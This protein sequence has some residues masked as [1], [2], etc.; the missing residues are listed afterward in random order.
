VCAGRNPFSILYTYNFQANR[1]GPD[2]W[3]T[4]FPPACSAPEIGPGAGCEVTANLAAAMAADDFGG[5]GGSS[6]VVRTSL[7]TLKFP[8]VEG[9]AAGK[10]QRRF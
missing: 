2:L 4:D 1:L 8:G 7:V 9:W 6:N 3:T 5:A 10:L